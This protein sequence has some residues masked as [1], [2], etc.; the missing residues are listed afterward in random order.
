ML[1]PKQ[2]A[3]FA[4]KFLWNRTDDPWN[5]LS[6]QVARTSEEGDPDLFGIWTGGARGM[7]QPNTTSKGYDF[8]DTSSAIHPVVTK[9]VTKA[10][11]GADKDYE[12]KQ[13]GRM[14]KLCPEE[15]LAKRWYER[16]YLC[17]RAY[18]QSATS[19]ALRATLDRCPSSFE[20]DGTPVLCG[21]RRDAPEGGRRYSEC[22]AAGECVCTGEFAKPV[23]EVYPG[24]G[25]E[26]CTAPV[27]HIGID[28]FEANKT[29]VAEHQAVA[30]D[31]WRFYYFRVH[32]LDYQ[33]VVDVATEGT[34]GYF[35][36]YMKYGQPP[37]F[38]PQQFDIRP[39][40][41]SALGDKQL[42]IVL[43]P[44]KPQ[45][46]PGTWFVG[47]FG[48]HEV[49]NF[50]LTIQ[51]YDCPMNCSGHGDCVHGGEPLDRQCRCF[52]GYGGE[53]CSKTIA[54]LGYNTEVTHHLRAFEYDYY[55][56]PAPTEGMK[57]G[58]VLV[59]VEGT[60]WSDGYSR[61]LDIYPSLL[62]APS[63]GSTFPTAANY[64]YKLTL[65]QQNASRVLSLC[66]SELAGQEWKASTG[67]GT[68]GV[69]TLAVYNPMRQ[70]RIGYNLTV[71]KEGRCLN[72]CTGHGACNADGF[73]ECTDNWQ[74]GDCSVSLNATC[75]VGSRRGVKRPDQRGTCWQQCSCDAA[76][77]ECSFGEDCADFTCDAAAEGQLP[78]RRKN[79]ESACVQDQCRKDEW[80]QTKTYVC[81]RNCTC[82]AD[83][84]PCTLETG[85]SN[86]VSI[87]RAGVSGLSLFWWLAFAML[88]GAAAMAGYVHYRGVPAWLPV[89]SRGF[90]GLYQEL[91]P[92][93]I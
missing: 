31:Q 46:R 65:D 15:V 67:A 28:Q 3:C 92:G 77:K 7:V 19:F 8:Q 29:F 39:E 57:L 40:W 35:D 6:M 37:N 36:M 60:F 2:W 25:F 72:N 64:T 51:K 82:P 45:Y 16:A 59:L 66:P 47:V 14:L 81:L 70:Y 17:I 76:G 30:P 27:T 26:S 58:S 52:Q 1:V 61:H 78:L 80:V 42:E 11:F 24:L 33:V 49:S 21:S 22:T 44:T 68:C 38:G 89:R 56:L 48:S 32:E 93:E 74:G 10:S 55:T 43:D 75:L 23:P 71:T 85:C 69:P 41:N 9:T 84:S 12:G 63:D 87:G 62:L 18:G 20:E 88:A 53:D 91:S 50:T 73:C 54:T 34:Y 79:N 13:E 86:R 4:V 90:G 83:G 5:Y